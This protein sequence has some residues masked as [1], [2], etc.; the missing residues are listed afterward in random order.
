MDC[1]D[2]V[3]CALN[4]SG[5]LMSNKKLSDF[6][7]NSF[8]CERSNFGMNCAFKKA[9]CIC[10]NEEYHFLRWGESILPISSITQQFWCTTVCRCWCNYTSGHLL[11]LPCFS[12]QVGSSR[13][14]E[15]VCTKPLLWPMKKWPYTL[16]ANLSQDLCLIHT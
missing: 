4:I 6:I 11:C 10:Y 9:C 3:H 13:P 1:F 14:A 16:G 7:K 8:S 5:P 2:D 15:N 12:S